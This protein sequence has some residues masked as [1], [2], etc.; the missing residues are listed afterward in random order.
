MAKAWVLSK[1]RNTNGYGFRE[2]GGGLFSFKKMKVFDFISVS[3]LWS[4]W[5][6]KKQEKCGKEFKWI[7]IIEIPFPFYPLNA[8][9]TY[10]LIIIE[11]YLVKDRLR[12]TFF[13]TV[14]RKL[15]GSYMKRNRSKEKQL[16]WFLRLQRARDVFTYP[17][18]I[19]A[20]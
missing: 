4:K 10:K 15:Y 1:S 5:G 13:L 17:R 16:L 2:K 11:I 19:K 18:I 8:G 3:R 20:K 14:L 9:N 7:I 12:K 6:E